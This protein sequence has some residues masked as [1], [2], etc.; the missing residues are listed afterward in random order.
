MDGVKANEGANG[1]KLAFGEIWG[2]SMPIINFLAVL[3]A[4]VAG[5]LVGAA[6]YG[7][8]GK[9]WMAA[10]GW[11]E[12]D[13]RGP[14]GKRRM[15]MTPMIIAF[16]AQLIMALML[17]G[18]VGHMGPPRIATGII[19]GVLV[20][21][22]FVITTITVNNAFQKRGP[23]LTVIDGGHWLAVLVVQGLILGLFG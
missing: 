7:V 13:M 9:Q 17:A 4:G 19:S 23:M 12:A 22:G 5:W 11:T 14:D 21:F 20:W 2:D 1:A 16:V 10:L 6:W 18:I 8:L 15:P 3:V